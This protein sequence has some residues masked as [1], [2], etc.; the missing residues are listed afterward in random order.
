MKKKLAILLMMLMISV[1]L[2]GCVSND[3]DPV[4]ETKE[5]TDSDSDGV[6]DSVD[7]CPDVFNPDQF[8][9]FEGYE[10]SEDESFTLTQPNFIPKSGGGNSVTTMNI[11][12]DSLIYTL[13]EVVGADFKGTWFTP[14]SNIATT[15]HLKDSNGNIVYNNLFHRNGWSSSLDTLY[16]NDPDIGGHIGP[17]SG[18]EPSCFQPDAGHLQQRI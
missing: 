4:V 5:I 15:A 11:T 14:A 1:S 9:G 12:Q 3:A 17:E 6:P 18:P 13:S 2:A 16:P 10:C 7:N 8:L